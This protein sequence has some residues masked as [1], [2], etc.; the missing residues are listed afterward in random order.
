MHSHDVSYEK[1]GD[2]LI[3]ERMVPYILLVVGS[4]TWAVAYSLYKI[5]TTEG[6]PFI[7]FVFWQVMGAGLLLLLFAAARRIRIK[8]DIPHIRAYLVAGVLGTSLPLCLYAFVAPELPAGV[9]GLTITL[10]PMFTLVFAMLLMLESWRW[11]RVLGLLLGLGGVLLVVLPETGLP[12][13]GMVGWLLLTLVAPVCFGLHNALI[14]RYWPRDCRALVLVCGGL[15]VGGLFM[16]PAMAVADS[17]W[18]FPNGV[19]RGEWALIGITL[20]NAVGTVIFFEIIRRAGALFASTAV[21][22][23]TL[24]A[25]GWGVLIFGE[26]HSPWVWA[27]VFILLAGLYLVNR[28]GRGPRAT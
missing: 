8:L 5:A 16:V 14:E 9:L 15:V 11:L 17:W 24:A 2:P 18:F 19:G 3:P 12:T 28:V 10:E 23:E 27:S 1:P 25:I 21:Y 4:V 6:I 26:S 20:I 22:I 13:R 7:P